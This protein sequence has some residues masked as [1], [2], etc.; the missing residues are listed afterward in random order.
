MSLLIIFVLAFSPG[1]FWLW[2]IYTRDRYRPEPR[3]LVIRTFLLGA[4]VSLPVILIEFV[5]YP[6]SISLLLTKPDNI[7][8]V[9]YVSFIVAGLTEEIGKYCV[10]RYTIYNSPYF[11]EPMDGI[12]YASAAALGF[13]S[14]ENVGYILTYGWEVVLA[15]GPFSTLAHVLFSG[16]WG[17]LLGS[18]KL[19]QG[20]GHRLVLAGLTGSIVLHG[21]FDFFILAQ[22]G[23]EPLALL[24]FLA[25]GIL[26]L[27]LLNLADK[28]SPYRD[29]V[30][31][32]LVGCPTCGW[33][34]GHYASYC[35]QC[36]TTLTAV[37]KD[38]SIFC[39]VCGAPLHRQSHFCTACGSRLNRKLVRAPK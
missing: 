16:M 27:S 32:P 33:R 15:R 24:L 36:G 30:S 31:S 6:G 13:A 19:K 34:S 4:A 39:S 38:S 20:S 35:S 14:L 5:L 29:K 1:L 26:F 22:R 18:Q 2:L 8:A 3:E 11:D 10:V 17:Y 12:V 23:Y 28:R 21:A 37:T 7:A 25:S 9:A